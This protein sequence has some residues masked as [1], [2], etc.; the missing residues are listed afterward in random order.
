M[1]LLL[2]CA[3]V[4]IAV[5]VLSVSSSAGG[6]KASAVRA[7]LAGVGKLAW[8]K[9]QDFTFIGTYTVLANYLGDRV[10]YDYLMGASG[11]AFRVQ[12]WAKGWC[13]SAACAG[14]GH[15]AVEP[16]LSALGYKTKFYGWF[17][18]KPVAEAMEA[19]REPIVASIDAG[20]PVQYL[21]MDDGLVIG[22]A[23][24]GKKLLCR[25]YF[26]GDK[27]Y[28][29]TKDW[30]WCISVLE[31]RDKPMDRKQAVKESL[32]IAL[33]QSDEETA[34]DYISGQKAYS[35]WISGLLD[36]AKFAKD[37][38]VMEVATANGFS[39]AILC[40]CRASATRYLESIQDELGP[41]SK[42]HILRAGE[43][44]RQASDK[45]E[46]G[47]KYAPMAFEIR[48][49][50]GWTRFMRKCEAGVLKEVAA[51]DKSAVEELRQAAKSA[52]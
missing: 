23:D 5:V 22:Y 29:E 24:N 44:Y 20:R 32:K 41:Q 51:L 40:D 45:L 47:R 30:P 50:K 42:P 38:Y 11:M 37:E 15:S 34:G 17:E 46:A 35:E 1:R 21:N 26:D 14:P 4:V 2:A 28:T 10:T 13:S 19:M 33:K 31:A 9:G 36:E 27:P 7:E 39:Y 8:G 12:K 3:L 48:N 6:K 43:F 25:T 49:G 18:G 16:L 52:E